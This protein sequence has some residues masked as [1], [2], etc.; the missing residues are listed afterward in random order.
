MKRNFLAE[1]DAL[2]KKVLWLENQRLTTL[3]GGVPA[4]AHA[5]EHSAG[6]DD[7]VDVTDLAGY[8]GGSP[9]TYL[10]SN[11]EFTDPGGLGDGDKGDIVVS[12]SGAVW[13]IDTGV[14]TPSKASTALKTRHV[15]F[16]FDGQ[17]DVLETGKTAYTRVPVACTIVKAYLVADATGDLLVD[18][19]K[20]SYANFPPA[21]ADSITGSA[22]PELTAD[23]KYEDTTLTGWTTSLAAG[24]W[25]GASIEGT[26]AT[27]TWAQLVLEV[28]LT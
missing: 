5:S 7:E 1:I 4:A 11:G 2:W 14:V 6:E 24:D 27:V 25:I 28:T 17:G 12:G 26:P 18:V 23:Q 10:D 21:N 15:T 8:P 19:W 3:G 13:T 22:E 9:V 20:D 16:T